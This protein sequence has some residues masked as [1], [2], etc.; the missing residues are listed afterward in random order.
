VRRKDQREILD[1]S[2]LR[3]REATISAGIWLTYGVGCLG[4]VYVAL[5]WG[6]PNRTGL[7]VLFAMAIA[8]GFIVSLLPRPRIVRSR[9]RELFFLSWTLADFALILLGTLADGGTS[10]PIVLVFFIPVVFSSMSYPL[11]SVAVVGTLGVL[12]YLGVALST[13]G[14]SL[15]YQGAFAAALACTAGMSGWHARNHNRQHDALAAASCADPL[16][17]C[18]NRRGFEERALAEI[19]DMGRH[20]RRGAVLVLDLDHFKP[21]N[22]RYGHAA[23]DDLLCWVVQTL[24][25]VVRPADAVGRLGGDEFAVLFP[26]IEPDDARRS[27][28]RIRRALGERAPSSVGLAIFPDDGADLEALARQ[29]DMRL[30]ASR[31]GRAEGEIAPVGWFDKSGPAGVEALMGVPQVGEFWQWTLD[32]LTARVAVLGEQGEIVAANAS[33]RGFAAAEGEPEE[34]VGTSYIDACMASEDPVRERIAHGLREM[35]SDGRRRFELEYPCHGTSSRRWFLVRATRHEGP[36]P[37]RLVVAHEDVSEGRQ[38]RDQALIQAA[39]LDQIDAAVI[40]TDLELRVSSWNSAAESLYGWTREEAVGRDAMELIVPEDAEPAEKLLAE[41][42][43]DSRWDGGFLLRRKDGSTFTAYVRNRL[44]CD[45]DGCPATLVGVSVDI[46]ERVAAESELLQSRDYAQ[47]VAECMGEGL[48][49]LDVNGRVTYINPAAEML[50]GWPRGELYGRIMHEVIH[51][52]SPDG[53]T[54]TFEEWPI[55]KSLRDGVTVRI[56]DDIF[57]ARSGREL[58]VAYTAAPFATRD[59]VQGCAVIFQD[60]AER[61]R[62]EADQRRDVE[63]LACINRVEDALAEDRFVLYAQPIVDLRTG[64]AVQHEL[65][66]RMRERDGQIVAPGAFL[67]VAEQYALIGEIDWWVIKRA[68]HIAAAG[69]P[70]ELNISARSIGDLDVLEHIERSIEQTGADPANLV[71]E[72]TETAIVEDEA[73]ARRFAERLRLL[74]CKLALDDFGTGYGGFTYLK[75]I[76]VDYLKIDIE[77]VRDLATNRASSHVVQAVVALAHDFDLETVGEGVEDPRTLELLRELGVDF[78]Q[79][80]HIARPAPFKEIPGDEGLAAALQAGLPIPLA[81][82]PS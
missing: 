5:T 73:A 7:A 11:G 77:F 36:G 47:A 76:P 69:C 44:I 54:V 25:C 38:A 58:P 30:Y 55:T 81:R 4:E 29:A 37:L 10:S 39:L 56:E 80:D 14:A 17:G 75:Q 53:S 24:T 60:V 15:T 66:L 33:W 59:G 20:A 49:T 9:F 43:R 42:R 71:F 45:E 1:V 72:I 82:S 32:S 57:T 3:M 40:V 35:I 67:K 23:G 16:T 68:A 51:R 21:V 48:F 34:C 27:A 46:S 22:D 26:E 63:T 70:V 31:H 65:L 19:D 64:E 18:L 8:A 78:A 62:Q 6:R 79:G 61:K 41:L 52:R 50:L 13:G 12:S 74:G 28:E 2:A